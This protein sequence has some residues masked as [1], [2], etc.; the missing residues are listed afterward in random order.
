MSTIPFSLPDI[1]LGLTEINGKIYLD[2]EFVVIDVETSLLGEFSQDQQIVKIEP[3]AIDEIRLD[4]GMIK[5]KLCIR[6]KKRELLKVMPG[7]HTAELAMS[8]WRK[9]RDRAEQLVADV[10]ARIG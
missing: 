4:R 5:D 7:T 8:I 3:N 1:N 6:P 10:E 9:Y 2:E